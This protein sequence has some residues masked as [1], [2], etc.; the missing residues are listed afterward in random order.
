MKPEISL[1][2]FWDRPLPELLHLLQTTPAGL[3][4]DDQ[5]IGD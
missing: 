2:H 4:S 1:E 3:T 5:W